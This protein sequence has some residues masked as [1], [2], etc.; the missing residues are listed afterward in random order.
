MRYVAKFPALLGVFFVAAWLGLNNPA[1]GADGTV[2]PASWWKGNLHTHSL[3]SDGDDFPEMISDWYK[4]N[5]YN[6]LMLSDHNVLAEGS[7]WVH[8][9]T[10]RGG[11]V[12]LE[13][14]LARF[15]TGWV[16]QRTVKNQPQVRLKPLSE[17]RTLFEE[18]GRFLLLQGE[19]ITDTYKKLP[20]HVN[21]TNLREPIPPQGGRSVG[22]TMQN[23]INAV[24]AQRAR[25]GQAM[26]PHLNHPNFC[27]AIT[28]EDFMQVRGE[29][30]FEVYNGHSPFVHNVGDAQ[31]AGTERVWDIV[32]T[33]RL[34]VLGEGPLYALA[35]D[36][37][38]QYHGEAKKG[39][40]PGRGWVMV[41]A[42][43]LTPEN[44][45]HAME[46]GDFYASTGVRLHEVSFRDGT[47]VVEIAPEADVTYTTQFIGTRKGFDQTSQ[48]VRA[49][50]GKELP[51][52]RQ[53]SPDIGAVLA[54]VQ[55]PRASYKLTGDE[56]YV[57]AKVRSSKL[58]ADPADAGEF[59]MAWTQPVVPAA[60]APQRAQPE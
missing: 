45:I 40:R 35:T 47:L 49:P 58:K 21:A 2:P 23:N 54:E 39:A 11:A 43:Y 14:Y 15:G 38:H 46:A 51:V 32:Q 22:Q 60:G 44:I 20:V 16:E 7:R 41:R 28:A 31:H 19:E 24:L 53:Y 13:K 57:R 9:L 6:F 5:G 1:V 42:P 56:I 50:T 48:P 36:D 52:T 3:W 30:F 17:Y 29:R 55:G 27:W 8:S 10:N 37:A 59:E 33:W 34:A 12:A 26:F 25:T 4:R 18:P